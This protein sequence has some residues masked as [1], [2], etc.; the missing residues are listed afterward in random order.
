MIHSPQRAATASTYAHHRSRS[1]AAGTP[2]L[3]P[4]LATLRATTRA[5][6]SSVPALT[7][8]DADP[9]RMKAV[10]RPGGSDAVVAVRLSPLN[11]T[12]SERLVVSRVVASVRRSVSA[13]TESTPDRNAPETVSHRS[14]KKAAIVSQFR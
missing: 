12:V 13:T 8:N 14:T 10:Y 7:T 11:R 6:R 4:P 5:G 1:G 2:L 9:P 3:A